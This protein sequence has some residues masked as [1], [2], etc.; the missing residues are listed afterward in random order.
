M[1]SNRFN[2]RNDPLLEAAQ[3]AMKDGETRR[4][5]EAF[6][7]EQFGVYSRKAVVREE[8][9]AYD[10][11]LEE[12]YGAL[13]EGVQLDEISK[14]LAKR[15]INKAKK[16]N[17]KRE[18]EAEGRGEFGDRESAKYDTRN[19]SMDLA[20]KKIH[21]YGRPKVKATNEELAKKDYDKDGKVES[22]KDEV[23]GSRLRAAKMAGKLKEGTA[24]A[25][26]SMS[27]TKDNKPST[28]AQTNASTSGPSASDKAALASKIK[29]IREEEQIDEV[30]KGLLGRYIKKANYDSGLATFRSGKL[31]GKELATKKV[32]KADREENKKHARHSLKRE[33]GVDRAVGKLTGK[34]KVQATEENQMD[35]AAYSAKAARAGKDIGK[36]GKQFSKIAKSAAKK[37]GSEER[38]KKVAGAILARIRAKHMKEEQIDEI[39]VQKSQMR[40]GETLGMAMNRLTGKTAIK[41]GANDP[42]SSKFKGTSAAPSTPAAST[43]TWKAPSEPSQADTIK[44]SGGKAPEAPKSSTP[45]P[46]M[47][48]ASPKTGAGAGVS[49]LPGTSS[50]VSMQQAPLSALGG[51]T[52]KDTGAPVS[53]DPGSQENAKRRAGAALE[54]SVQIGDYKY[55]II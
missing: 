37:Y 8:L 42:T 23:W 29:A 35:E 27:V 16:D 43:P 41:G 4:Q 47:T 1:F 22:P 48:S 12:A 6:V 14:G 46:T 28:P 17:Q 31:Y 52:K 13:K 15:Y 44:A 11:A 26:T 9:A 32:S 50:S 3:A 49:S 38:G 45:A 53:V 33:R 30:S 39:V 24:E 54:E 5:A 36:P 2:T 20:H 7:N 40:P 19:L 51:A 21:G 34:A 55:R 10:A 18:D 25:E